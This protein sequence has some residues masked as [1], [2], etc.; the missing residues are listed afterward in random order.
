MELFD[1]ATQVLSW[2]LGEEDATALLGDV[3]EDTRR[4]KSAGGSDS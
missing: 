3:R 1:F 4:S 2:L